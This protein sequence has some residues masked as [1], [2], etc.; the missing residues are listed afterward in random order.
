MKVFFAEVAGD[1][2]AED[3]P[4]MSPEKRARILRMRHKK[5]AQAALTAHRLLC[6]A[7][8]RTYGIEP[9]AEDWGAGQNGKP[10]LKNAN[11][12]HFNISHSG[13]IA[14]CAVNDGP[15][16]VD[17]EMV[18][19]FSDSIIR[20]IMSAEEKEALASAQDRNRLFFKIWTLK[21]AYLKFTGFGISALDSI[22]VYPTKDGIVTNAKGCEFASIDGIL[23]YE[24]AVCAQTAEFTLERVT[25]ELWA[26]MNAKKNFVSNI[27]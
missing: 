8:K 21:E 22:T 16:G 9:E 6:Y 17:V 4:P 10:Y 25:E 12:I 2:P 3:W 11:D 1:A 5:D 27:G 26:D 14:M 20:R 18:R 13:R 24:A 7:L 15:V 23:G 19:P